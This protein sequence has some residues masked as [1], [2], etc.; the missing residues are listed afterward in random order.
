MAGSATAIDEARW[1]TR[2]GEHTLPAPLSPSDLLTRLSHASV[3]SSPRAARRLR[4]LLHR[5]AHQRLRRQ[6]QFRQRQEGADHRRCRRRHR[7]GV[8][9]RSWT[10]SWRRCACSTRPPRRPAPSPAR[11]R[12]SSC[13]RAS[14]RSSCSRPS[15]TSR[16]SSS[17]STVKQKDIDSSLQKLELQYAKGANGKVDDTK[18][19][20]VLTDNHTSEANVVDNIKDGLLRQAIYVEADKEHHRHRRGDRCLLHEEQGE[21]RHS[22]QPRR[23][24]HPGQGQ[25]AR[26]QDLLGALH[27]ATRSS[28]RSRRSTRSTR[29]R[30]RP[31]ASSAPSRRAR[32]SRPSTRS[33]SASRPARSRSPSRAAT[34]GT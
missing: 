30:R 12:A 14:W 11:P 33:R 8:R 16:A 29:A 19:K 31:A 5:A 2:T 22:R 10:T 32:P 15:S 25:G 4:P 23:P 27:A 9:R 20:K 34:A 26:R 1:L 3:R 17:R 7:D 28:L 13:S 6:L 24:P 21:L 18:W